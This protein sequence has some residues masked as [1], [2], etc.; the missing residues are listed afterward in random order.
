VTMSPILEKVKRKEREKKSYHAGVSI[1]VYLGITSKQVLHVLVLLA[2]MNVTS[3]KTTPL[4]V[5]CLVLCAL[6][7]SSA[8][9]SCLGSLALSGAGLSSR[10]ATPGATSGVQHL[11]P[12]QVNPTTS[13]QVSF[14]IA[15]GRLTPAGRSPIS[16]SALWMLAI[17][18]LVSQADFLAAIAAKSR[19]AFAFDSSDADADSRASSNNEQ[20][21]A[22]KD[23][24]PTS[25][26]ASKNP[27]DALEDLLSDGNYESPEQ[28]GV[29][30]EYMARSKEGRMT[31]GMTG[32]I[33]FYKGWISPILPPACR[34]VPTCSQY[35][36]QAI[37]EFGPAKGA[38]LT[39]WRLM[40][41]SPLGGKGYDPPRWPPVPYNYA[42]Y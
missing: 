40:R 3:M 5:F 12:R 20:Q 8:C 39:A 37:Q 10:K 25:D 30:P 22:T 28:R 27:N 41:C 32:A 18:P 13:A 19:I 7:G 26:S 6:E 35:G 16:T 42:S 21:E 34:F 11:P 2:A 17:R 36:V 14:G 24:K 4:A 29:D 23:T 9:G 31:A 38:L 33:G 1:A 15:R